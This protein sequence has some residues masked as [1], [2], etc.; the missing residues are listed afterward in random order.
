MPQPR[1]K[2]RSPMPG[3]ALA[4]F[5]FRG[6]RHSKGLW[7]GL[8]PKAKAELV[9]RGLFTKDGKITEK[10]KSALHTLEKATYGRR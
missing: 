1:C 3:G 4:S 5:V 8:L 7:A 9:K 2:F 10:G 6:S